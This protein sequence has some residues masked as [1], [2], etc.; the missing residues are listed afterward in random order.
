MAPKC[1]LVV[2]GYTSIRRLIRPFF[3]LACSVFDDSL[4]FSG[5]P[6]IPL[7]RT[8]S[9]HPYPLP[10]F[11]S[12]L[13]SFCHLFLGLSLN[14]VISKFMYTRNTFMRI[15]LSSILCTC[16]NQRNLFKLIFSVIV[17]F[18]NICINF[19]IG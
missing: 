4:P 1:C 16:Q 3:P 8:L 19:F 5:A 2:E 9:C 14:L 7:L 15:L 6:S 10:I 17:G 18:F 13:T 12:S 11:P